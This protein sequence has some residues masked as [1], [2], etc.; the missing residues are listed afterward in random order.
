MGKIKFFFNFED[1]YLGLCLF[2]SAGA[3]VY[4]LYALDWLGLGASFLISVILYLGLR[5]NLK[6]RVTSTPPHEKTK[7]WFWLY[8]GLTIVTL[9]IALSLLIAVRTETALIS[10]WTV[11]SSWF[12]VAIAVANLSLLGAIR[13]TASPI[14]KKVL[15][16]AYYLVI[17]SGAAI[18]YKLGYGF[19]P[20]IHQAAMEEISQ[21]GY[22][23][24]K[25]P[26]YIGL[27]A[28][29]IAIHKISGL[30]LFIINQWLLPALSALLLPSLLSI[31]HQGH[32]DKQATWL[33][34]LALTAIGFSPLIL[35]TPQNLS[36]LLLL[37]TVIFVYKNSAWPLRLLSALATFAVHPLA[38]IPAL[39][40]AGWSL[41]VQSLPDN[42]RWHKYLQQPLLLFVGATLSFCLVIWI[43]A[44]FNPPTWQHLNLS[45]INPLLA[46]NESYWLNFSYFFIN[47]YF[48]FL[49]G[50]AVVII[51]KRN[52]FWTRLSD[53]TTRIAKVL[54]LGA[55]GAITA[56]IISRGFSFNGLIAYEQDDYAARLPIIALI[57]LLPLYWEL[58]YYLS[59]HV[60]LQ[61][62][63]QQVILA[64]GLALILS[65]AVYASYPRFDHYHN[66][67]GY[68][69]SAADVAA[70]KAA[71]Y[72]AQGEPYLAL[73][74]QQVSAAALKELGFRHYLSTAAGD[75]Y[76]YPIPTGGPLYQYFLD[77]VYQHADRD[78]M[79]KAME[80]GD[81]KRAYLIINRYW[82][83]SDKIIAEAKLS[84]DYWERINQ[85]EVYLFEYRQ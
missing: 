75:I 12:F 68:S 24:P 1:A 43:I 41:L 78:T 37:A 28:L 18:V 48:W 31:L 47:N 2:L 46:N 19:D 39:L 74:N 4:F 81:V 65:I 11:V 36:Y 14:F 26:Y 76:F 49:L 5:N 22:I 72:R 80:L 20:F 54:S 70:V 77:M 67:R 6:P 69:T 85:G 56:Y 25:T 79:L 17:F 52:S 44:G 35:T 55:L 8:A 16:G 38:G 7:P 15:L 23:L 58:G 51:F 63:A 34:S 66:S 3:L 73:A 13:Q 82:W 59:Q 21:H 33:A 71:N 60:K 57:F 50:L 64:I 32:S 10:P 27:Y 42:N 83:A 84:A 29:V 53:P 45:L 40:L 62:R 30:S 9:I 61:T